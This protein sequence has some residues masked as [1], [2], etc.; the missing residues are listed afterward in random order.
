MGNI[1]KN[2]FKKKSP[3]LNLTRGYFEELTQQ[4]G[5]LLV[6]GWMLC[7]TKKIDSFALYINKK[8]VESV[9]VTKRED[10]AKV[11]PFIPF[12]VNSGFRFSIPWHYETKDND[13]VDIRVAGLVEGREVAHMETWYRSDL[14]TCLPTPPPH[15]IERVAAHNSPFVY[16]VTGLQSYREY[17]STICKH[18]DPL[19]IDSMLDW[20]CG[21]GRVSGF[22]LKFSNIPHIHGCDV[23]G[24]A[25]QWCSDNLKP[26]EFSVIRF[27]PPTAY[28]DKAFDLIISFSIFTHLTREVQFAWLKEMHRIL[29][30]GGLFLTS[31][32]GEFATSFSF[33]GDVENILKNGIY[34]HADNRLDG[35]APEGYYKGTFQKKEYTLKE[36]SPYFEILEYGEGEALYYQDLVVMKKR[37]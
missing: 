9:P 36:W 22:F 13:M 30:P 14:Y 3:E 28:A 4:D 31:V 12:V 6:S 11:Y 27:Y 5:Q 35:I 25:I 7:L 20:G 18:K 17:W 33:P 24:E 2:L 32:H 1:F 10:V 34:E 19:S 15:L 16:L 29:S 8:K 23:D 21:C 37:L 26:A